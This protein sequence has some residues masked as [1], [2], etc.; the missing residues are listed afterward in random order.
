MI[1][2]SLTEPDDPPPLDKLDDF[3]FVYDIGFLI[4]AAWVLERS[5]FSFWPRAGGLEDQDPDFVSDIKRFYDI[6]YHVRE[7]VERK[8]QPGIIDVMG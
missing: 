5:N 4:T 8:N 1:E 7:I 2:R 3:G 6:R